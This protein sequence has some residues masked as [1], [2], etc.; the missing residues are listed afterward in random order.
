MGGA[1]RDRLRKKN[2]NNKNA[3]AKRDRERE[4]ENDM[5]EEKLPEDLAMMAAMALKKYRVTLVFRKVSAYTVYAKDKDHAAD[6]VVHGQGRPAGGTEPEVVHHEVVEFGA[7]DDK[8]G[9]I[10]QAVQ[11]Q[12]AGLATVNDTVESDVAEQDR[13]RAEAIFGAQE[14]AQ[15]AENTPKIEVVSS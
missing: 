14:D 6:L 10:V 5:A 3:L 9:L 15:A 7:T 12:R 2:K 11:N 4:K 8:N 1:K 13:E